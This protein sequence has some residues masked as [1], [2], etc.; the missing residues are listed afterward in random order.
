[1]ATYAHHFSFILMSAKPAIVK[2]S[3]DMV[4]S[5]L[6]YSE[7]YT[8]PTCLSLEAYADISTRLLDLDGVPC[9]E[10]QHDTESHDGRLPLSSRANEIV[11]LGP[12]DACI[13]IRQTLLHN[14][15]LN[16][17]KKASALVAQWVVG[18]G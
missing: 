15:L 2:T 3:D 16:I 10:E 9:R 13:G 1:M 5:T 11:K 18:V 4:I 17:A 6:T 12:S 14:N 7:H 8:P